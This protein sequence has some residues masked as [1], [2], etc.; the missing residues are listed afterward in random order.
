MNL[1]RL[2]NRGIAKFISYY[3]A[4]TRRFINSY[5]PR[6]STDI[7]WTPVTK[8]LSES[9]VAVV[10]TA[11][12]HHMDDNPFNMIDPDG[13]PTFRTINTNK[14][15][16]KLMI[17]HDYYNHTGADK[18]INIVFP[19]DRLKEFEH[20]GFIGNVAD[21][22]YGFMGHIDGEHID[23]LITTQAPEVAQRLKNDNVDV[24]LLTPG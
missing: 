8:P 16:S 21:R 23:T 11:G 10:T 13:D 1:Q 22:H 24:V 6:E 19:V 3:P 12:V 4:L 9:R 7:P 20:E 18:D 15:V 17:T 14:P 5:K 2:K